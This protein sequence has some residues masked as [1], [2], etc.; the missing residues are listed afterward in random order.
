MNHSHAAYAQLLHCITVFSL[1]QKEKRNP[2]KTILPDPI[3]NICSLENAI[4][5]EILMI[6]RK[7]TVFNAK[8]PIKY[9]F[10]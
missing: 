2:W 5:Y 9:M 1:L 10:N 8:G 3:Y 7:K 4:D 6:L